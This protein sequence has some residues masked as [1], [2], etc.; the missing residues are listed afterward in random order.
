VIDWGFF[1]PVRLLHRGEVRPCVAGVPANDRDLEYER[2][3]LENPSVTFI[4]HVE[5]SEYDAGSLKR[6]LNFVSDQG[7]AARD[8][9]IFNDR[10][11]R[12]TIQTF[13]TAPR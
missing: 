11:G 3:L 4:G 1:E 10:N 7:Y 13:R 12:P 9:R 6:F 8:V 2:R 5:G